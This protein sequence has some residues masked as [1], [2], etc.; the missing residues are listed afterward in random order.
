M[1]TML[2]EFGQAM[3]K[4]ATAAV[5]LPGTG[6]LLLFVCAWWAKRRAME[7]R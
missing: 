3:A 5:L 4:L 6:T 1:E 2:I 7:S